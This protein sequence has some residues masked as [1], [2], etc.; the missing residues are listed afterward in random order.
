[1]FKVTEAVK[2][3]RTNSYTSEIFVKYS[4]RCNYSM[5]LMC[6]CFVISYRVFSSNRYQAQEV[7]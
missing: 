2:S 7:E 4:D 3:I 5:I 1:M 6:N